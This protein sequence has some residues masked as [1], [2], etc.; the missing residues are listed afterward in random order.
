MKAVSTF[1]LI[2]ALIALIIGGYTQFIQI[3]E[4]Q[5]EQKQMAEDMLKLK[6]EI[7]KSWQHSG[8]PEWPKYH[9]ATGVLKQIAGN[10]VIIDQ[11]EMPGFMRAMIMSYDVENPEQL[12]NLKEEDKVRLKLKE[13]E[14]N[15]TVVEIEKK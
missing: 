10:R 8:K 7:A 15:L 5:K 6:Q 12:K 13:T 1:S 2:I 14:T 3:T 9:D 4:L 11:D